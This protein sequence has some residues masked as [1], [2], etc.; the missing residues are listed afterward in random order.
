MA[1]DLRTT[2]GCYGDSVV[3]SPNIDQLA[4]KSQV[5]LNTYAQVCW[6]CLCLLFSQFQCET[7]GVIFLKLPFIDNKVDLTEL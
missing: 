7:N 3:K 2:L 4:S 6:C 5:F 1:D